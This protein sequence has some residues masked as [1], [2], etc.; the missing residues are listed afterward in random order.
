MFY[1]PVSYTHLDVYKRQTY[2]MLREPHNSLPKSFSWLKT[3]VAKNGL[4]YLQQYSPARLKIL[5]Y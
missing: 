5:K 3:I 2:G 1:I 4:M